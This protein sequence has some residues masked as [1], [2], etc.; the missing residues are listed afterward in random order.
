MKNR[1]IA[2]LAA[3]LVMLAGVVGISSP[4]QAELVQA[5]DLRTGKTF[6]MAPPTACNVQY[7][8][9]VICLFANA[10]DPYTAVW[11]FSSFDAYNGG[12]PKCIVVG[13]DQFN[14]SM[15]NRASYIISKSYYTNRGWMVYDFT[16]CGYYAHDAQ[17]PIYP[18]SAGAMN[19]DW[20]NVIGSV[21]IFNF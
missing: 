7:A 12:V 11:R 16:T 8:E 20:D 3:L 17:S 6:M 4:A 14:A 19:T 15:N 2:G 5:T 18:N 21:K 10:N 13:Y 1:V 9:T